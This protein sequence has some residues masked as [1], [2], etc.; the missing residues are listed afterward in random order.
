MNKREHTADDAHAHHLG[1]TAAARQIGT[2]K[3]RELRFA[4]FPPGQSEKAFDLLSGLEGLEVAHSVRPHTLE[5]RYEVTDYTFQGLETALEDQGFHLDN[6]LY[7]KILR[8]IAHYCEETQLS[9]LRSPER[10]IKN[11]NEVYVQAWQH[12][13]HG[14]HD[15]TPPE[16]REYK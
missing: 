9:N 3:H 14:D 2:G 6:T 12:H 15:E 10:L 5:V 1:A 4:K 8:A 7:T 13:L 16:L 11:S